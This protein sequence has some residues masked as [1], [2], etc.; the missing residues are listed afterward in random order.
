MSHV[1]EVEISGL[2][3]RSKPIHFELQ[4][5]VNVFFGPN[6]GGKTSLLKIIHSA[7][8][9]D[10][11]IIE[12]TKFGSAKVVIHSVLYRKDVTLKVEKIESRNVGGLESV[13]AEASSPRMAREY[14]SR[15]LSD[16]DIVLR[17]PALMSWSDSLSKEEGRGVTRWAH[18]YLPTNR[19][20]TLAQ[21]P[22]APSRGLSAETRMDLMFAEKLQSLWRVRYGHI[23]KSVGDIQNEGLRYILLEVLAPNAL[24][25]RRRAQQLGTMD[26]VLAFDRMLSFLKRQVPYARRAL[27]SPSDFAAR[28]EKDEQLRS[29]V[30]RIENIE[31]Q[32][33]GAT[34]PITELSSLLNRLFTG[35]KK[36]GI[37]GPNIVVTSLSGE[38]IGLENLSSGEKNVLL[39]L[40]AALDAGESSL[41]ID[42][43]E[44]SLHIDWQRDLINHIRAINP[45]CQIIVATHS[46]EIMANVEDDRIFKV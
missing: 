34:K 33:D 5:D 7:M 46:P 15:Y 23:M 35:G 25:Q 22:I 19:T 9:N 45:H 43:P 11:G 32:I 12:R 40:L 28:F 2:N 8:S 6:G 39:I 30:L 37:D 10:T 1:V 18:E 41:I 14:A 16:P 36:V 24:P 4:R 42:E 44:I 26:G 31:R 3:G 17:D 20:A 21:G 13:R 38:H 29:L 27:G